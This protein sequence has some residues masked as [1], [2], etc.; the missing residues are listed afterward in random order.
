MTAARTQGGITL[1]EALWNK[2]RAHGLLG[3][4][5]QEYACLTEALP[6]LEGAY[7]PEH[8]K[9]AAARERLTQLHGSK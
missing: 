6:L 9:A 4:Y 5:E 8:P 1:G 2:A 3:D 7:G